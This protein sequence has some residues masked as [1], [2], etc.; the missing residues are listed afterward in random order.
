MNNDELYQA[1]IGRDLG[2]YGSESLMHVFQVISDHQGNTFDNRA[3]KAWPIRCTREA[4]KG[5]NVHYDG[6]TASG[7]KPTCSC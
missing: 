4:E 6:E 2:S 5:N 1:V 3:Q 7:S